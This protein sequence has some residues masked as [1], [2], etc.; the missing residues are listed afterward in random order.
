[1][2]ITKVT[3]HEETFDDQ[4]GVIVIVWVS[5]GTGRK[6]FRVESDTPIT[7]EEALNAEAGG[8]KVSGPGD[9]YS[10][11]RPYGF[12]QSRKATHINGSP[13]HV[14]VTCEFKDPTGG[15][16]LDDFIK[17]PAKISSTGISD[18]EEYSQDFDTDAP[19][20]F[21]IVCNTAGEPYDRLPTR[22]A[23]G[24][25]IT[26]EKNV[27]DATK[28]AIQAAEHSNNPTPI[29]IDGFTH[30]VDTLLL[31]NATFEPL[32]AGADIY[33]ATIT[34]IYNPNIW[35]DQI[36]NVGYQQ[37]VADPDSGEFFRVDIATKAAKDPDHPELPDKWV[38]TAKP[39]ALDSDGLAKNDA[40]DIDFIQY[41]PYPQHSWAGVPLA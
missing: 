34:V 24:R 14:E 4:I 1:M 28:A 22:L 38:P 32:S 29:T 23:N 8:V 13:Y 15:L 33:K 39:W 25:I 7:C 21:K 10:D 6:V 20:G 41:Y 2:A 16:T 35:I 27:D 18:T 5:Y 12:L 37:L 26:I 36:A 30:D 19:D 3:L 9:T 17:T 31:S 11:A 40:T